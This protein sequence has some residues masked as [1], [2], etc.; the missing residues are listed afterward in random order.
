MSELRKVAALFVYIDG[1]YASEPGVDLWDEAR[2]ARAYAGT[3]PV[4]AHPPC[5]RW[6][7]LRGLVRAVSGHL[8]GDDGGCF[9]HALACVRAFGGVLEHP[10]HSDA[11]NAFGLPKP[12]RDGGWQRGLCG[13]WTCRIEQGRYGHVTRKATW[14]HAYGCDLSSMR[15]G[16]SHDRVGALVGQAGSLSKPARLAA[17]AARRRGD[18]AAASAILKAD[19]L[20][21]GETRRKLSY[22]ESSESPEAFRAALLALARTAVG[23]GELDRELAET[24]ALHAR[25]MQRRA[26]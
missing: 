19:R 25:Y 4:V 1:P 20:A 18:N 15:W 13:G 26:A 12:S 9:A 23:S 6:G 8:P 16:V 17:R 5:A 3:D 22:R 10:A 21:R 14:L 2:D 11:F 24:T 7:A